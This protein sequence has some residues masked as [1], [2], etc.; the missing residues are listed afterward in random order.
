MTP[1]LLESMKRAEEAKRLESLDGI[2][3]CACH[4]SPHSENHYQTSDWHWSSC[5]GPG[6]VPCN[7]PRCERPDCRKGRR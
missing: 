7:N 2:P 3:R 1:E 5:L 4:L 6:L